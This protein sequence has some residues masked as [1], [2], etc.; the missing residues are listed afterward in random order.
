MDLGLNRRDGPGGAVDAVRDTDRIVPVE[1]IGALAKGDLT[2]EALSAQAAA[3][4]LAR[5]PLRSA[6]E[7]A[8]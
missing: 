6:T 2:S 4:G 1:I 8:V 7:E 3:L 5:I